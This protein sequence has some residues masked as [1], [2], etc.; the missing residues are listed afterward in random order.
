MAMCMK[1]LPKDKTS[2][3]VIGEKYIRTNQTII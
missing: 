2:Y 1:K 3:R